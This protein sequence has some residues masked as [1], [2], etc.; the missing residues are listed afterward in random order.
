MDVCLVEGAVANEDNLELILQIRERTRILV[1]FGDCAVTG[2]VT[3]MR[4]PLETPAPSWNAL[5]ST[6]RTCIPPCPMRPGFSPAAPA[7]S[8]HPGGRARGFVTSPA[9]RPRPLASAPLRSPVAGQVPT[10][11]G[12]DLTYG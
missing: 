8:A 4:N 6:R 1:A 11:T 3:A 10:Q 9:A 12:A 2:N 7:R 5:T